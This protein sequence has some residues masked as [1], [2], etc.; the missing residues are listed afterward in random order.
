[1]CKNIT[2]QLLCFL[3][4]VQLLSQALINVN[5]CKCE[6]EALLAKILLVTGEGINHHSSNMAIHKNLINPYPILKL[7]KQNHTKQSK[8]KHSK[9]EQNKQT[10]K[11][12][13]NQP[14]K[15]THKP[16]KGTFL[17]ILVLSEGKCI[18]QL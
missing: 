6:V 5:A 7:Q 2:K 18:E 12:K 13:P 16:L 9:Q 1:M 3:G 8:Q 10:N 11:Q 4:L 17:R 15:N 14:N